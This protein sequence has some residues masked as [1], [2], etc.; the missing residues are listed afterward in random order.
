MNIKFLGRRPY[1]ETWGDMQAFTFSRTTQTPDEIWVVEHDPV[2]TQGLAGRAEHILAHGEIPIVQ[3][4]RGGQVTYHGPGQL[5]VYLLLDVRRLDMNIRAMVRAM[6]AAVVDFLSTLNITARGDV[7][8]PGVYV[9]DAK[10]ASLGLRIRN[11][12]TYHGLSLNV[13]MDLSPFSNINP[14]GYSGL[15]VTQLK[16]FGVTLSLDTCAKLLLPHLLNH[17]NLHAH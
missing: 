2:Y 15:R 13:D 3:S 4:D 8:A 12:A 11:H 14:C 16:E 1:E 5:V 17:L 6:E 9:D 7:D 10:I